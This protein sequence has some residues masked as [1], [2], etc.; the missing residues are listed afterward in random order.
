MNQQFEV[1]HPDTGRVLSMYICSTGEEAVEMYLG[2]RKRKYK[3]PFLTQEVPE[4]PTPFADLGRKIAELPPAPPT[5]S[6][7]IAY[8]EDRASELESSRS[9]LEDRIQELEAKIAGMG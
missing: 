8:L 3:G 5:L 4:E 1:I 7:R 2:A 6:D 9:Y